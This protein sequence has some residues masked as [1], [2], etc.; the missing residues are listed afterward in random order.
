MT[1]PPSQWPLSRLA[2]VC[3]IQ[4]GK[5]PSK[6]EA[7]LAANPHPG[8]TI[9]FYKVG[10]M[11]NDPRYLISA[12]VNFAADE[13]ADYG[14][15]LVRPGAVVF[16][17]AGGAIATNKKRLARVAG[18]V[19]LNCMAV[20]A[21]PSV[22]DTYLYWWFQQVDLA[23]LSDGSILPQLS[24][25]TIAALEI[26]VPTLDEQRRI[27]AILEDHQSRL[28]AAND[29]LQTAETRSEALQRRAI[30]DLLAVDGVQCELSDLLEFSIGGLW[31]DIPGSSDLDVKVLR[32]TELGRWGVLDP[33]T[34]ALRSISGKQFSSRALNHGD[35]LLEK[36]GGGPTSPVGR[37][38][39][40]TELD[41][42][43]ICSNFMQL[44][45]PDR[46][47]V[48]P[49]WLHLYLNAY[50]LAGRT[51]GMQKASTNIRNIKA[52]DYLRMR[53]RVP[54]LSEQERLVNECDAWLL[55]GGRLQASVNQARRDASALRRAILQEAFSGQLT[56]ESISV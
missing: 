2:D 38:G 52:S 31:G 49:R 39:L 42:P 54:V 43:S 17:K 25:K 3:E 27:V 44:M 13:A 10:D 14:I 35:L 28:D 56:R 41:G 45:R 21:G 11:A 9:P 4:A 36:S 50:H 46:A 12:R 26:P 18:G 48:L 32:V 5:T 1:K 33:A 16:P 47:K 55:R 37:V 53:V 29:A 22:D 15:S 20:S 8:R 40:V 6:F 34:A 24:K 30:V 7:R 51:N 23:R 19:D